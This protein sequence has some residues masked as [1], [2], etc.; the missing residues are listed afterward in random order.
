M[1]EI[2]KDILDYLD[3]YSFRDCDIKTMT[4]FFNLNHVFGSDSNMRMKIQK[5]MK[6]LKKQGIIYFKVVKYSSYN[7]A[8]SIICYEA[9]NRSDRK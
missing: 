5:I 1:L 4:V 3:T 6:S 9:K 2:E 7:S 8:K